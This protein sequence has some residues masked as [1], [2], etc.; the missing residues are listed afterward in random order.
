VI[1]VAM[2]ESEQVETTANEET[3]AELAEPLTAA[4]NPEPAP[5]ADSVPLDLFPPQTIASVD[6]DQ[7]SKTP[8]AAPMPPG[9][10]VAS[11]P[12]TGPDTVKAAGAA[13]VAIASRH[14]RPSTTAMGTPEGQQATE[15]PRAP[16]DTSA[17]AAPRA[18][19]ARPAS[20]AT[21]PEV[22]AA[23]ML[24]DA[25]AAPAAEVPPHTKTATIAA[26]RD[27]SLGREWTDFQS[28]DSHPPRSHPPTAAKEPALP[29]E[30][31]AST[32][33]QTVS[34]SA[35]AAAPPAPSFVLAM[36][37]PAGAL[38]PSEPPDRP[39][40]PIDGIAVE[41]AT[42]SHDGARRFEIRLDPPELGRID[43]R[44]DVSRDGQVTSRL[45]VE[46]AETLDLL[47]RDAGTLERALQSTGLRTDDAG[48]QF[49]LRDQPGGQWSRRDD[50]APRPSVVIV[51][52]ED[53]AVREAVRRGYGV[54]RGLG[55]GVDIRI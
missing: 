19:L 12:P 51:P 20:P 16:T 3:S 42:R 9:Q 36:A 40:V 1:P 6:L 10:A 35:N 47:R 7:D 24:R 26:E 32:S 30:L 18:P 23:A 11:L 33:T 34:P 39:A 17:F 27:T 50:D 54:L 13:P 46:R 48:L 8:A 45:V 37:A 41:I 28:Q 43:V 22:Q 31:Q 2:M 53:V 55:H 29:S 44:L 49:S 5:A 38:A 4:A 21:T 15:D 25:P 14:L 52:N